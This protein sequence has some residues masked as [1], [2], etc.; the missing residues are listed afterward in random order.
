M[1]RPV[2]INIPHNLGK[3]EARRRIEDGFG[4]M[5]RQMTGGVIGLMLSFYE[6][7]EDDRLY[8]EGGTFGQAIHGH[9][10]VFEESVIV[11]VALPNILA[12]IAD[13]IMGR[14]KKE[15]QLLLEKK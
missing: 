15:G 8:F 4:N 10:D 12:T 9:L 7:W 14:V 3:A 1:S 13:T 6:R 11:E 2:T 5:R